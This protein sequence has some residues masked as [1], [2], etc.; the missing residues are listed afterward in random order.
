MNRAFI[1]A[2]T[3]K[4]LNEE[5]LPI[6]DISEPVNDSSE[7]SQAPEAFVSE[8][9]PPQLWSLSDQ[10]RMQLRIRRDRILDILEREEAREAGT[11]YE[12]E[13]L[14]QAEE[15]AKMDAASK[16][17]A[18][19]MQKKMGKA[20]VKNLVAQRERDEKEKKKTLE[21]E[22]TAAATRV[23]GQNGDS[24]CRKPKKSVSFAN[25]PEVDEGKPKPKPPVA[26]GDVSVAKLKSGIPKA[27]LKTEVLTR[28][29]MKMEV[30]ERVPGQEQK[31]SPERDSDDESNPGDNAEDEEYTPSLDA[32]FDG[33]DESTEEGDDSEEEEYDLSQ[34]SVQREVALEYIR[35][36]ESVGAEA[37]RAMTS[38]THEG[39]EWEQPVSGPL[40]PLRMTV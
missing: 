32:D 13:R 26:W 8:E 18:R 29:P 30:V 39:N 23:S 36:R 22:D 10:E 6:I 33:S 12:L 14:R 2:S 37:A 11:K 1:Y 15:A 24:T 35:L 3:L 4:V 28:Q 9:D 17:A 5:G 20:L 7:V 21:K 34:A 40:I 31:S 25:V 27:E 16:A 19:E 38:H